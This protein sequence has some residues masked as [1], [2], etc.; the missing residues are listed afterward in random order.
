VKKRRCF[1]KS[2]GHDLRLIG[3]AEGR[4]EQRMWRSIVS[5]PNHGVV[6]LAKWTPFRDSLLG[7]RVNWT[8]DAENIY[9]EDLTINLPSLYHRRQ[10]T[11]LLVQQVPL[12][13]S[14]PAILS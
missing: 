6:T 10:T 4:R 9:F 11:V 8:G 7:T 1:K 5:L 14:P 13:P 2:S 3:E 12:Y